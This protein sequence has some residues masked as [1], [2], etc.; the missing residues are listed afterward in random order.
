MSSPRDLVAL[1]RTA[2]LATLPAL[3]LTLLEALVV[4]FTRWLH[5]MPAPTPAATDQVRGNG[6]GSEP[7]RLLTP[8]E[9]AAIIGGDVSAR[10]VLR[11]TKGLRFRRDLSR[12]VVRFEEAGLRRWASARK[13]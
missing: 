12:K 4:A 1:A 8:E 11:H 5:T 9:A 3:I 10:W 2:D 7:E 6:N 13:S